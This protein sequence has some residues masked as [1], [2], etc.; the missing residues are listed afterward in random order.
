MILAWATTTVGTII[1]AVSTNIYV[2]SVGLFFSGAGG[3]AAINICFFFFGEVV[4]DKK[5]Q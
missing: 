5:R 2:A 1:V 4:G 3:D